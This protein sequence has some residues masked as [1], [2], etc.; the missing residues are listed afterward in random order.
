M[1]STEDFIIKLNQNLWGGLVVGFA[2]LGA[3]E[4]F[5]LGTLYWFSCIVA[6]AM[7]ISIIVTTTVY[8]WRYVTLTFRDEKKEESSQKEASQAGTKRRFAQD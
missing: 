4:Y 3:S 1:P 7:L 2:S 5:K 6:G 8:T